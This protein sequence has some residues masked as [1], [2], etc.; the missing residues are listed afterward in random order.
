VPAMAEPTR[1]RSFVLRS[2]TDAAGNLAGWTINGQRFDSGRIDADPVLNSTERWTFFNDSPQPHA[3]HL[4]DV[5]WR[6]ERRFQLAFDANGNPVPGAELPVQPWEAA[7]KETFMIPPA[8]GF[9]VRTTFTD[10]VGPY[11]FHCHMLEHEDMAMMA[12]FSVR[13][14]A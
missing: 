3:I 12:Q 7:Q 13:R 5:D 11:V 6:L 2:Q 8:T 9:S 1:D 4:H 14:P 10:H